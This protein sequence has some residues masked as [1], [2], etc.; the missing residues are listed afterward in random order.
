MKVLILSTGT[1][2]GHNSAANAAKELFPSPC[3]D[4]YNRLIIVPG[5]L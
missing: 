3:G 5:Q 1:G 4:E 2:E